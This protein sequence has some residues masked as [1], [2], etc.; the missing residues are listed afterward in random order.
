ASIPSSTQSAGVLY[1]PSGGLTALQPGTAGAQPKRLWK[2]TELRPGTASPI[3]VGAKAFTLSD[4]GILTCGD[5]ATGK[6]VWQLRLKGPISATPV[7]AGGFLYC[8]SEK[9]VAQVVDITKP[10]GEIVHELDLAEKILCTPS[11]AGGAI[12]LRSDTR[13]WKLGKS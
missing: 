10:E 3:V 12:Y 2:S 9:G 6:R 4:G 7:A 1:V 8:V 11:I 5:T 13:L